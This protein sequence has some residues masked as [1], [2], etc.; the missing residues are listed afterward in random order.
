MN[1]E[2]YRDADKEVGAMKK[3]DHWEKKG[4]YTR[5][6]FL[7]ISGC[8]VGAFVIGSLSDLPFS[9]A[10]DIYPAEKITCIIPHRAGGGFDLIFRGF[11]RYLTK[12]LREVSP[13]AK[14]GD[15]VIKNEPAASGIKGSNMVYNARPNGYTMGALESALATQTVL[16][17]LDFDLQKFTYLVRVNTATRVVITNKKGFASWEEM[18]KSA[19]VR[20]LKW[21]VGQFGSAPHVD[22]IIL[23][24]TLGI[25]ARLIPFGGASENLNALLRGDIE[26]SAVSGESAKA[27]LDA[28]ELRLLADLTGKGESSG[29]PTIKDLGHPELTEK[30]GGQR[31]VICPPNLPNDTKTI[32]INAFR[33]VFTDQEF[34]VWAKK[35]EIPLSPLYGDEAQRAAIDIFKYFQQDLKPILMKYLK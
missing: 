33:K 31:F 1:I 13:G 26:V 17:E 34:V 14:G 30:L 25:P 20:D 23:K 24:E 11:S 35:S 27:L 28:G 6:G 29:I 8:W 18:L 3:E 7:K 5:R 22:S 15:I 19:K 16:S 9:F 12:Y 10:K 32:L 21:G 4:M 2:T